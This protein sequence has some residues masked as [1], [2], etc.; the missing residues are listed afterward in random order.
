MQLDQLAKKERRAVCGTG[1]SKHLR[2][3]KRDKN[4]VVAHPVKGTKTKVKQKKN[5][6]NPA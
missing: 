2:E 3:M 1:T 5:N 4:A 6:F